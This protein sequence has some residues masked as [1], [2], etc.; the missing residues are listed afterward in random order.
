M[1][2]SQDELLPWICFKAVGVSFI[3]SQWPVGRLDELV[4]GSRLTAF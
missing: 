1:L 4:A 3:D 2:L